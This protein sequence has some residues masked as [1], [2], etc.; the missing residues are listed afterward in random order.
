MTLAGDVTGSARFDGAADV[1]IQTTAKKPEIPFLLQRNHAYLLGDIVRA[2]DIPSYLHLEC[3]QAGIT[4]S[5]S[6]GTHKT[7]NEQFQDGTVKW[8]TVDDRASVRLNTF[9][10]IADL[11]YPVGSIYLSLNAT[12]PNLLFGGTWQLLSNRFLVG[13][14]PEFPPGST[15]GESTHRLT[16]DEMPSHTH[17]G[18][19]NSAGRHSHKIASLGTHSG[20]QKVADATTSTRTMYA[21]YIS[22]EGEH[23]HGLS[24]YA[25]GGNAAHNN[26]PPYLAVYMWERTA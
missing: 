1:T 6:I 16:V 10:G 19:T 23:S 17:S 5:G 15:G 4:G 18:S 7:P 26:L 11:I 2:E 21:G 20:G 3:I 12:N 24:I 14:G 9:Q 13:A 25:A 8:L 22:E